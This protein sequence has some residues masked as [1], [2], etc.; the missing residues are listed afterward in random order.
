MDCLVAIV[1]PT[2]SGKSQL[3]I[4]L[5]QAFNGEII[6]ADS[7]QIYR[8]MDIGTAKPTPQERALVPHHLFDIINPDEGFSLVQYQELAYQ[9][10]KDIQ[11]HGKLPLLVG[12][13]GQYVWAVLEGWEV[14]H[15]APDP[16]LRQRLEEKA[17][18]YG[19]DELYQELVRI[20]P[21]AAD[22][23]D[24]RNIR[25]VVRALEVYERTRLPFSQQR[26]KKTPPFKTLVI[27]LT[28]DRAELYSRVDQR[29]DTMVAQG[30][31]AEVEKLLGMGYTFDLPAMSSI[32]YRQVG[33]FLQGK[34]ALGEAVRQIK[35]ENHRLIRRQYSWFRPKDGRIHWLSIQMGAEQK[36]TELIDKFLRCG[37]K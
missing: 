5:A 3:A 18:A 19:G 7:R 15:V 35:Y 11:Q 2:G 9:A 8:H 17:T 14:P 10:I 31:V 27:G 22:M 23:I 30:F 36:A 37:Q 29:V 25:R 33:L 24:P 34:L 16:E 1:G 12:G 4:R 28:A 21:M 32:G 6:N 26:H 13:T 20:D